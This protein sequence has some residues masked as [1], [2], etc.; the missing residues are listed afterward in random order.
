MVARLG[1]LGLQYLPSLSI[2]YYPSSG[3][4]IFFSLLAQLTSSRKREIS[5]IWTK[6]CDART[7]AKLL[8]V[9]KLIKLMLMSQ[10][11]THHFD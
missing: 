6:K 2:T 4:E 7:R 9:F 11:Q 10:P 1:F 5:Q 8:F 3:R